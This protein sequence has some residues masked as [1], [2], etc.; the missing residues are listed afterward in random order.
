MAAPWG[1]DVDYINSPDRKKEYVMDKFLSGQDITFHMVQIPQSN[2]ETNVDYAL[3]TIQALQ[4]WPKK[5]REA[6]LKAGREEEFADIMPFLQQEM[7]IS[8]VSNPQKADISF[9]FTDPQTAKSL[10][11]YAMAAG[12]F[13]VK[14]KRIIL[15]ILES[16]DFMQANLIHEVGHFYGF[17]DFYK[18]NFNDTRSPIYAKEDSFRSSSIMATGETLGCDDVDGFINLIDFTLAEQTGSFSQRA[19]TGWISFCNQ[20]IYEKAKP[21]TKKYAYRKGFLYEM[22]ENN[23]LI[24]QTNLHPFLTSGRKLLNYSDGRPHLS[25]DEKNNLSI[26]Y[27]YMGFDG[28]NFPFPVLR[29]EIWETVLREENLDLQENLLYGEAFALRER[30]SCWAIPQEQTLLEF[31]FQEPN[32]QCDVYERVYRPTWIMAFDQE[33]NEVKRSEKK[34]TNEETLAQYQDLCRF[35][36]TVESAYRSPKF[37]MQRAEERAEKY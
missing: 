36:R 5:T 25:I 27:V 3:L 24:K 10:C 18:Y 32:F 1:I 16:K 37:V 6:I 28:K 7:K 2:I 23:S 11:N 22:D 33:G 21:K 4:A 13:S 12:C 29:A 26:Y 34:E 15:A 9:I 17:A 14:E 19:E 20:T 31:C 8:R 30:H 35:F